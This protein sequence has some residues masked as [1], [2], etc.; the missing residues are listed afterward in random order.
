MKTLKASTNHKTLTTYP[1]SVVVQ[2]S[3]NGKPPYY[4]LWLARDGNWE[5][6]QNFVS[7]TDAEIAAFDCN[8]MLEYPACAHHDVA[9]AHIQ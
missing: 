2:V 3:D 7:R 8:A 5:L 9:L 6:V 1:F 4:A